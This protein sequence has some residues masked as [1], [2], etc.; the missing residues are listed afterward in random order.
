MESPLCGLCVGAQPG[1]A[2]SESEGED[3]WLVIS[4]FFPLPIWELVLGNYWV[5]AGLGSEP[6][7]LLNTDT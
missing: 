7:S 6:F 4:G 3:G 1:V 2:R 5:F